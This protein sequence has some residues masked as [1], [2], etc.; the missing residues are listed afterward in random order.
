MLSSDSSTVPGASAYFLGGG[1]VYTKIARTALLGIT[2]AEMEGC[3]GLMWGA[4]VLLL[5]LYIAY[6]VS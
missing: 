6:R 4:A 3:L 5:L 2:D 1:V